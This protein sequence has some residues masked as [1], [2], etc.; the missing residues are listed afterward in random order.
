VKAMWSGWRREDV[1]SNAVLNHQAPRSPCSAFGTRI[2]IQSRSTRGFRLGGDGSGTQYY[3][4]LRSVC[5]CV[6]IY[7]GCV[8]AR[9]FKK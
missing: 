3:L 9:I 7:T 5:V 4:V 8:A 2:F 1:D 6:C